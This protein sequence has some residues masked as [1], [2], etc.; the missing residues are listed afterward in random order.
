MIDH[1]LVGGR[2][3]VTPLA[4]GAGVGLLTYGRAA[5][6]KI[7]SSPSSSKSLTP[8][9]ITLVFVL[10][11]VSLFAAVGDWAYA[12]GTK[13]ATGVAEHLT[14]RPGVVL[15]SKQRLQIDA[16]GVRVIT[17]GDADSAYRFRYSGLKLLTRSGGKYFLLPAHW[18]RSEGVAIV[19]PDGNDLRFEFTPR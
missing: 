10:I 12:I 17:V 2:A 13:R 8:L 9:T 1:P 5:R 19:L 15:Y 11:I 14:D 3:I 6:E 7:R 4:L 18:S 16:V